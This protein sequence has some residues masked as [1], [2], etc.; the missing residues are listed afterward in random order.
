[1]KI[2][3]TWI[4]E[5]PPV[6]NVIF[7]WC[8]SIMFLFSASQDIE[9]DWSHAD[10]SPKRFIENKG[11]FD[12]RNFNGSE[13][14]LFAVDQGAFQIYF[15]KNGLTYCIEKKEKNRNRKEGSHEPKVKYY[16]TIVQT[17]W[18]GANKNTKIIPINKCNDYYSYSFYDDGRVV[19]INHIPGYKKIV[20][21][22]LYPNIDVEYVFHPKEG[23]KYALILHP[24]ADPSQ[25][26]I[27]YKTPHANIKDGD[28]AIQLNQL[29]QIE[30][31]TALG[32]II[33][34]KPMSFYSSS[35][36]GINSSYVFENKVLTFELDNYDKTQ[37]VIIDPWI[38]SP[39]FNS[40]TAVWEVET[41]GAGNVYVIG[42]ETPMD[43]KKYNSAGILQWTYSTPW[44]TATVWLGTLATDAA[45]TSYITSGTAPEME[46]IDNAGNMIWHSN[47]GGGTMGISDEMWSITFNCDNT[48][49]IVGG[50][51]G[52]PLFG[53][54]Y[55]AAIYDIDMSN[56]NVLNTVTVAY[57]DISVFG[58]TPEEVRSISSSRNAKYIFLTHD[59]VGAINQILGVCP[60]D[61]PVFQVD[62]T[63]NLGYKCENYLP[64]GQNG[65]GLKAL[66]AN[67]N[68][69]YTHAGDEIHRWSLNN[70]T[71]LNSVALPGGNATTGFGGRVVDNSGLAVD[72]CG[73]VYAGSMN[74]VVKFDSA[75]NILSQSSVLFTVY[76]VSVNSNGEVLAVGAQSNNSV[77]N[78]NGRIESINMSAC[79]QYALVCCDASICPVGPFCDT[80][81]AINLTTTSPSG[82]WSGPGITNT[83]TGTFDPS[84]A[85]Q[86]THIIVNTIGCGS[87][88]IIIVVNTCA[89]L[90]V[91]LEFNGDLTVSSGT[92]PYTWQSQTTTQDCS[93]CFPPG[94]CG[95]PPGCDF[96]VTTW[97]TYSTSATAT[98]PGTFPIQ[99]IDNSSNTLQIDS[100]GGIPFCSSP[101][102]LTVTSSVTNALCNGGCDGTATANPSGGTSPYTYQWDSNAGNQTSQT[103]TVLCAGSYFVTVTDNAGCADTISVT[104]NQPA[105]LTISAI[106]TP[107]MC[108]GGSDGTATATP[109]GGAS[110][111]N[112]AWSDGQLTALATG[113]AAGTY[114]ITVTDNNNCI[115]DTTVVVTEPTILALST[116]SVDENCG[117]A[118]GSA[119]LTTN[120]GTPSYTYSWSNGQTTSKQL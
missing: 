113:L 60:T 20:Y 86:G 17:Q 34:H 45:G 8:F 32:N 91:C 30:I 10:V 89:I 6:K 65:G 80:D 70:G 78:R 36:T 50:T 109:S 100:L 47:G 48:K 79:A 55:Y 97:T 106:S 98:P 56:G 21:K 54:D 23:I 13:Q 58:A 57:T 12:G 18:V 116:S 73:N 87:D 62:N 2:N 38:V 82:T 94:N 107:I 27:Q 69:F 33:E 46:R 96:P 24:G 16:R 19:N 67:D 40:S 110:P 76:D 64:P 99:V 101:C 14:T 93:L 53:F 51:K 31:N 75:L 11:Q 102:T 52:P 66:V 68:Y 9:V 88:S 26:R 119:T 39:T 95:F 5:V 92:A 77:T 43:L 105:P 84:V 85:G 3:I 29:G 1:M 63:H 35:K 7:T 28:I 108:N 115:A 71:L 25:I 120:G 42:G 72:D 111:Y 81:P 4:T 44:D 49:L 112:Y 83:T 90:T 15:S 117:A 41:D 118:D 103:A 22:E 37:E 104:V 59:Q 114:I 74:N 61:D